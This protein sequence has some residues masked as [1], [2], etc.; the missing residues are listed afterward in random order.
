MSDI[1]SDVSFCGLFVNLRR[2]TFSYITLSPHGTSD[3]LLLTYRPCTPHLKYIRHICM[4][5]CNKSCE[6]F[7]RICYMKLN[8]RRIIIAV[9]L[10]QVWGLFITNH[11]WL[12]SLVLADC[13]LEYICS[14]QKAFKLNDTQHSFR[15]KHKFLVNE[16]QSCSV[17][18]R[19]RK[20]SVSLS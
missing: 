4:L 10:S 6:S 8:T 5:Y 13:D 17:T 18:E 11:T 16:R 20:E 3:I 7:Y 12:L 9:K 14:L 1:L 2:H 19:R 15:T